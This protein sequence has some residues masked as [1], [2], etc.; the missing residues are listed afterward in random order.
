MVG[1]ADLLLHQRLRLRPRNKCCTDGEVDVGRVEMWVITAQSCCC[2]SG[3]WSGP[4]GEH[5]RRAAGGVCVKVAARD[6]VGESAGLWCCISSSGVGLKMMMTFKSK[7]TCA[8]TWVWSV[9]VIDKSGKEVTS[10]YDD[11][12]LREER[13]WVSGWVRDKAGVEVDEGGGRS[14]GLGF[15]LEL[16]QVEGLD[17]RM[18]RRRRGRGCY[19]RMCQVC[20]IMIGGRIY[21][22]L[23]W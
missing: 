3:G 13:E 17:M 12:R 8:Q 10:P 2:S 23:G 20:G 15:Q 4:D 11:V 16:E 21:V 22:R 19:C 1:S 6:E 9:M 18:S 5:R 7:R 14:R